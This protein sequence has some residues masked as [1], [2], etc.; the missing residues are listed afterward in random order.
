MEDMW[1]IKRVLERQGFTRDGNGSG[2]GRVEQLP[3]REQ[4]RCG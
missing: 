1:D 2:S 4:R 3:A